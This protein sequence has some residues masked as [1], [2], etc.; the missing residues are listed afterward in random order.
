MVHGY[1]PPGQFMFFDTF[2]LMRL[3][4]WVK[5]GT[6]VDSDILNWVL[7]TE[8]DR[9][10]VGEVCVLEPFPKCHHCPIVFEYV[11][12][13]DIPDGSSSKAVRILWSKGDYRKISDSILAVDWDFEFD[14][15]S[16]EACF[17]YFVHITKTHRQ[18]CFH[19]YVCFLPTWMKGLPRWLERAKAS[20]WKEYMRLRR[21]LG[22]NHV[23]AT[24][25]LNCF[26]AVNYRYRNYVIVKVNTEAQL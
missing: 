2:C 8:S 16:I 25:A 22:R 11:L 20:K 6:F 13:F 24:E 26:N 21:D 14:S 17:S 3:S 4:Q 9:V 15:R 1:V 18:V 19:W 7:S 23:R 12:Q 5:E 10:R